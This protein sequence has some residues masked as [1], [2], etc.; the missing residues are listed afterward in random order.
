MA[1]QINKIHAHLLHTKQ[2]IT[3]ALSKKRD[4]EYL[5]YELLSVKAEIESMLSIVT[6]ETE[7]KNPYSEYDE[8]AYA[9]MVAAADENSKLS[10]RIKDMR[11]RRNFL[12]SLETN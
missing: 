10:Q 5:E 2:C 6:E 9:F 7:V 8:H 1:K 11:K 3:D 12:R 4:A